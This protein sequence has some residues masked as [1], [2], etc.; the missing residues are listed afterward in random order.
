MMRGMYREAM[1]VALDQISLG[2][3]RGEILQE[4]R[5]GS[6]FFSSPD[7]LCSAQAGEV[8]FRH[9]SW[10]RERADLQQDSGCRYSQKV[11]RS[12]VKD[13]KVPHAGQGR[14]PSE[15]A[16]RAEHLASLSELSAARRDLEG[17]EVPPG[18]LA[19]LAE[20]TNPDRRPARPRE[21]V[22][23]LRSAFS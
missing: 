10:R 19:T 15:T 2:R 7:F 16:L 13:G 5:D 23:N 14:N 3:S 17:A 1:G 4:E 9:E 12:P 18:T 8:S 11:M 6:I 21:S 20:L 22:F